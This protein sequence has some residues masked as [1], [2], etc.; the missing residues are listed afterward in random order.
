MSTARKVLSNTL[1]QMFGRFAMAILAVAS[2]KIATNYD[3]SLAVVSLEVAD[4][5]RGLSP[6]VRARVFEPYFSTKTTGTGL[7]LTIARR[8][9]E[10]NG[11]R[12][13][14]ASER[15]KGTTV[16]LWLP[17]EA[18]ELRMKN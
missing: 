3:R 11:G 14:V 1:W 17:G 5:G 12:I 15:G 16:R 4:N 10:S 6:E 7:G 9:I 8:N 18:E 2:V 13:E